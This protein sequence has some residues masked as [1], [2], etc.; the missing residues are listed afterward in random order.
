MGE[1][2]R[3]LTLILRTHYERPMG[4]TKLKNTV[5]REQT[6]HLGTV[7]ETSLRNFTNGGKQMPR[8][9][10]A[11]GTVSRSTKAITESY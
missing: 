3:V 4:F 5:V 9:G 7:V 6:P 10:D 8:G 1:W 11:F 2:R